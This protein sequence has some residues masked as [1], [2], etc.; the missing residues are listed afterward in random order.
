MKVFWSWQSDTVGKIGRHFVRSAIDEA[1]Q[2][3]KQEPSIDEPFD[4]EDEAFD[5]LHVDQDRQGIAGSPDLATT[6]FEKIGKST[7][8][9]ADVTLVGISTLTKQDEEPKKLL[10][11]NVSVELGY[12]LGKLGGS[13]V[14]MVINEF[15]GKREHLPFDL[16]GKGGALVFNLGPEAGK[17][18]IERERKLLKKKLKEAIGLCIGEQQENARRAL[19]FPR[20]SSFED[21]SQFRSEGEVVG[22]FWNDL[23]KGMGREGSVY[24]DAGPSLWIRLMPEHSIDRNF[25]APELKKAA[26]YGPRGIMLTPL[27]FHDSRSLHNLIEEDGI[28]LA[29]AWVA[30]L[31]VQTPP[32]AHAV[33]WIFSTGEIWSWQHLQ[34]GQVIRFFEKK[35]ADHLDQYA[36][37]LSTLGILRPYK[38]IAGL[39]QAKGFTLEPVEI[40]GRPARVGRPYE[41][42]SNLIEL[43]GALQEGDNGHEAL[44]PFFEEVYR[45]CSTDRQH[46][47]GLPQGD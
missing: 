35:M 18:D 2:A 15:Y 32:T 44:L 34:D 41:C 40:D 5:E 29:T 26:F 11:S 30:D 46:Y 1:V 10:N 43:E 36:I 13:K 20:K 12:A 23:P 7:V 24:A 22:Q 39:S 16:R 45:R 19:P 28:G 33:A 25:S 17:E 6:I 38:W 21:P 8:F 3:L 14:L 47:L 37:V 42:L 27:E 4:R 31:P 9:I